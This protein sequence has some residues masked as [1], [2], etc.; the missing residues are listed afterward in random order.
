V[1]S[2]EYRA[3]LPT[4]EAQPVG[5]PTPAFMAWQRPTVVCAVIG[6]LA[7]L[8]LGY[9]G[10]Q[11]FGGRPPVLASGGGANPA[12]PSGAAGGPAGAA[13]DQASAVPSSGGEAAG[14]AG[15]S[16]S[17][18]STGA[19]SGGGAPSAAG[20]SGAASSGAAA[21][22][23]AFNPSPTPPG[24]FG[25]PIPAATPCPPTGTTTP[26]PGTGTTPPNSTVAP[27]AQGSSPRPTTVS[28]SRPKL[29][30]DPCD[31]AS[32]ITPVASPAPLITPDPSANAA[33]PADPKAAA[34]GP[35]DPKAVPP[36]ATRPPAAAA[37]S[38]PSPPVPPPSAPEPLPLRA[39]PSEGAHYTV[40][41]RTVD[42]RLKMDRGAEADDLAQRAARAGLDVGTFETNRFPILF[43]DLEVVFVGV[44]DTEAEARHS[45]EELTAEGTF[46]P[47]SY[48]LVGPGGSEPAAA[49]STNPSPPRKATR[50]ARA[51]GHRARKASTAAP[52]STQTKAQR[53]WH[54]T[55]KAAPR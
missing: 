6:L 15:S 21:V 43:P 18:P 44:F 29:A 19:S 36:D 23:P 2:E 52:T 17:S 25:P 55:R 40:V 54:A 1:T 50:I 32:V 45:F 27:P 31:A 39:F 9:T 5:G 11:A 14:A 16:L 26:G 49:P 4:P 3:G 10:A 46:V 20:S 28:K 41:L 53:P 38:A 7:S 33:P 48:V 22:G 13:G 30:P 24:G 35:T 8:S 12:A 51:S 37:P 47:E 42:R 34:P